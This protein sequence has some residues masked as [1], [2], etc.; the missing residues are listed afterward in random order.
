M[1]LNLLGLIIGFVL[2]IKGAD[3]LVDGAVSIA[4]GLGISKIVVGLSVVAFGTSLPELV[5]SLVSVVKGH[6]SVSI[7]NV[8]G[9]NIANIAIAL[10]LAALISNIKIEKNTSMVEIPFMIISTVVFTV[11]FLR[12]KILMWN[13]GV[14]F[15][16]LL[17]I[18]LY[19]LIKSDKEMVEKE[20]ESEA[21]VYK[22]NIAF[23]LVGVGVLGIWLGGELTI[24][25]VVKIAKYFHLSETFVGLTIVAIGTSLPEIVV[26]LISTLKKEQDILV[27]NIVG[28]NIF[29]ILFILG[30]SSL[31]GT[32]GIDVK[33]FTL[34]L[35]IMNLLSILLF[36]FAI[37]RKKIGKLEG[38]VFLTIYIIYIYQIILRK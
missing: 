28:S 8:V 18:Y 12:E 4:L 30:I 10:A 3:W 1:I 20:F 13:Y 25:N 22:T 26:S 37:F 5:A 15:V 11:L 35:I 32:L 9:S 17:I 36:L 6:S 19:Y 16:S 23:L 7:S 14:V 2:L 31:V 27:G 21:K 29:N 34:D 38:I 24:D 33:S